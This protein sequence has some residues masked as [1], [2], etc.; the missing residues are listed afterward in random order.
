MRNL[1]MSDL[2]AELK[3]R[4]KYVIALINSR[5]WYY[6]SLVEELSINGIVWTQHLKLAHHFFDERSVEEFKMNFLSPRKVDI[7]RLK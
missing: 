4:E 7:L 1:G 2:L 3:P 6:Q 5:S